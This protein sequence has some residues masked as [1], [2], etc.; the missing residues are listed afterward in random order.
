MRFHEETA[1][2]SHASSTRLHLA[3]SAPW[4]LT[5]R[6]AA[7]RI[8]FAT[9]QQTVDAIRRH[10]D[11][12][13]HPPGASADQIRLAL[14][15]LRAVVDA[16]MAAYHEITSGDRARETAAVGEELAQ[17]GYVQCEEKL[18]DAADDLIVKIDMALA[19]SDRNAQRFHVK[20]IQTAM[21]EMT[22]RAIHLM[23]RVRNF[24]PESA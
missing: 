14:G 4:A 23:M 24:G 17:R 13:R 21:P 12:M 5:A 18:Y 11:Q 3:H 9:L 1:A 16:R 6:G 15:E 22:R 7:M 8:L 2:A 19:E 20:A 10:E